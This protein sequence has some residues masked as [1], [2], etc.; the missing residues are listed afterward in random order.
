MVYLISAHLRPPF[1][2]NDFKMLYSL[3]GLPGSDQDRE[4]L[5]GRLQ[6][7]ET[8]VEELAESLRATTS[9]MEQYQAMA[10]SLEESLENEKQVGGSIVKQR[11]LIKHPNR[12]KNMKV[13]NI[14]RVVAV[15]Q[16][17]SCFSLC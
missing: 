8:R 6:L 12:T 5:R 2:H 17:K 9:S 14:Q 15:N 7:A 11:Q 3:A 10:Q 16:I 13:E 4:D 1:S